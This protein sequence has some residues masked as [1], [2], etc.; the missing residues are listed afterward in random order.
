MSTAA[1]RLRIGRRRL[2][3]LPCASPFCL[4]EIAAVQP[5][6]IVVLETLR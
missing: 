4:R 3:K 1:V 5:E 6:V 2:K